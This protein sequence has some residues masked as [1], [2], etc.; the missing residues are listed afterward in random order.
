MIR[1][2]GFE[3]FKKG[4]FE[5][6]G[7]NLFVDANGVMRRIADNDLFGSGHFDIVF[8]NSHA[9]IE[10][11][12]TTIYKKQGDNY[13][14]SDLPH[15]SCWKSIV[16]D[17]DGDG[18]PDLIVCDAENGIS[19]DLTSYIYWGGPSG[20]TGK[21][22]E[23][24]TL[25]AYDAAIMDINNN[26]LLDVIF[27]TAWRDHHNNGEPMAQKV[28]RQTAPR[29]FEEVT[30]E[31]NIQGVATIS[32]LCEDLSGDGHNDLVLANLRLGH[33]YNTDSY[34]YMGKKDGFEAQPVRLPTKSAS[35]VVACDLNGDGYKEIVFSGE[36]HLQ[37]FWSRQGKFSAD[38]KTFIYIEGMHG[39]FM[40]GT[41][42]MACAD[43][44]GDGI[45]EMV[46]GTA[47]GAQI[48]KADDIEQIAE[49]VGSISV[50]N[51]CLADISGDNKSD[52]VLTQYTDEISYD[53]DSY[54]YWS[55][56]GYSEETKT[57][58]ATH[59]GMHSSV[60][61]IDG[62][63]K[64]EIVFCNTM[65]GPAQ[66]IE[67]FPV[68]V[69]RGNEQNDYNAMPRADYDV[70]RIGQIYAAA[71]LDGN[72]FVDL[73][74]SSGRGLIIYKGTANG[75]DPNDYVELIDEQYKSGGS[76]NMGG[77][78]VGDFNNNGYLDILV[79]PWVMSETDEQLSMSVTIYFGGAD[80]Y[81]E[82]NSTILPA[83][84][85]CAA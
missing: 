34:V 70:F 55:A 14:G 75:P 6:G 63:G 82:G 72:G 65:S 2:S 30:D 77:M 4:S 22:S 12:P 76:G 5:N 62:D 57:A 44:D 8:P 36:D 7:D 35:N 40:K 59:G 18:Y 45:V 85:K 15:D 47:N 53:V 66:L 24:N 27:G 52:I 43:I 42:S 25:G 38:D 81:S 56:Q 69:Y 80:G 61:D 41:L 73:V 23:F 54:V 60:A 28:F 78:L 49:I 21:R 71:D 48:R 84:T 29:V 3:T 10:R 26:G 20:L 9:Y 58:L 46:I 68:F 33:E 50:A 64:K 67:K 51:V 83:F 13:I 39:Q 32:M 37:I 1:H 11:A 79:A 17:V 31:Y 16:C 19:S 74:L